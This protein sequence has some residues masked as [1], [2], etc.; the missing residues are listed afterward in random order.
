M[1]FDGSLA[2][3]SDDDDGFDAGSDRFFN[4]VLNERLINKR[5]HLFRRRFR[6]W[7]KAR[8]Q[9]CR[10]K[11]SLADFLRHKLTTP[12][13]LFILNHVIIDSAMYRQMNQRRHDSI[14]RHA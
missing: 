8:A 10:R 13:E 14:P 7:Q 4:D 3:S 11:D 9:T 2:A 5:Q 1:I 6:G 12:L